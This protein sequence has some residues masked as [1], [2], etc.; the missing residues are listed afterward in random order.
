[1]PDL[2]SLVEQKG[3]QPRRV[4]SSKGGEFACA[5]PM[6]GGDERSDRFRI[7]PEQGDGGKWWCR[8]CDIGGDCIEFLRKASGLSFKEAAEVMGKKTQTQ[9]A[10]RTPRAPQLVT[11]PQAQAKDVTL[12]PAAWMARA[13]TVVDTAHQALLSSIDQIQ[14]LADR[15]INKQFAIRFSLGWLSTDYMRPYPAWGMPAETWD[16]G[17]PKLLRVPLGLVIPWIDGGNVLRLRVRQPER[18]PKYLVIPGGA[19]DPQPLMVIDTLWSGPHR[20]V[21]LCE[22]E[23]D[24]ILLAQEV[25]DIVAVVP[26]G[27]AQTRPHDARSLEMV[28]GA[29]WVGLWLDRDDA[30][31]KGTAAWLADYQTAQDIRPQG[32]GKQ[33]PGEFFKE[34]KSIR[35]HV[36]RVLPPVWQI[37]PL[38]LSSAIGGGGVLEPE[39]VERKSGPAESVVRF[40]QILRGTPII[41]RVSDA[42]MT[43]MAMR[44]RGDGQW[45]QDYG[46]EVAHW[47]LM[48]E[49]SR[50][51]WYD[52][53]VFAF[54][55]SHPSAATGVH[56]KNYWAPLGARKQE[57]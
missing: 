9:A 20:A 41:C 38:P 21:I 11:A 22:A 23:L 35:E 40:G 26:L 57:R 16:N 44:K 14:W 10:V 52:N 53:E 29:A 50:L 31:D 42:A 18:D 4:S 55:E 49:A 46:W 24:A 56:G 54:V 1:M 43:I 32:T 37:G 36:L 8:Q 33:D 30:G 34:G 5:C 47:D 17:R 48:R 6:C 19:K 39:R 51:F 27:S 15:G 45:E 2:L 12:P 3:L 7:W 28:R 25:G 13:R